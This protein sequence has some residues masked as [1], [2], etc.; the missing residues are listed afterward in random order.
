L[1]DLNYNADTKLVSGSLTSLGE[2]RAVTPVGT[3]RVRR[4]LKRLE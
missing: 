3:A 1:Y 4:S 2:W